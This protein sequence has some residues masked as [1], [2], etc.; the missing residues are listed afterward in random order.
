MVVKHKG[1]LGVRH[2]VCA[3]REAVAEKKGEKKRSKQTYETRKTKRKTNGKLKNGSKT[4]G[5]NEVSDT[6]F[7]RAGAAAAENKGE[8]NVV[9]KL[10][11]QE[12]KNKN[13]W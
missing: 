2:R 3:R 8:K 5:K 13:K 6:G 1:K 7:A 9:H 12:N 10:P 4:Q 11:R